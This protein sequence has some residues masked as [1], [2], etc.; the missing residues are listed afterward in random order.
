MCGIIGAYS[1]RNSRLLEE[2]Y[3]GLYALQHRGQEAAGVAWTADTSEIRSI[4]NSGLVHVALDQNELSQI[5]CHSAI[6]HVRYSTAGGSGINNAQPLTA[7]SSSRGSFAVAH[8]GNITNAESLRSLL[9]NRGA[10]FHSNSDT[11]VLLHLITHQGHKPFLDALTDALRRLKGAYSFVLLHQDRLIAVRDPWGFR[12]LIL[13]RR[14]DIY[15]V[16]SESCALDLLAAEPVR[17]I[18]PGEILIIDGQGLHSLRI[19]HKPKRCYH[20]SFEYVYFARPDSIIDGISVYETRKAMGR[21]LARCCGDCNASLVTGMPD[22]GTIAALG[23]AEESKVPYQ[24]AIVRNRYS[25]RTFIEPTQR[26]RELGVLKKLNPMGSLIRGKD[27]AVVDDSIVR[28]TTSTKVA[29]LLRHHCGAKS[30]HFCISSP[31]VAYPC[32][33]G[34]DTPS[35]EELIAAQLSGDDLVQRLCVDSL[36]YL[37]KEALVRSIGLPADQLC[38]ACFDGHYME[39]EEYEQLDL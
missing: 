8:N 12:P 23:F 15:Y 11:E 7:S 9:E 10:I 1:S 33:Y 38:T 13:G 34:I 22:S 30:V 39:E 31:P 36:T 4:K 24:S 18:E 32:Y 5:S 19:P 14:D 29:Q 28:G 20:C 35:R 17:D 26:V 3:L 16:V 25:G 2:I 37:T 21:E 6:G 27:L